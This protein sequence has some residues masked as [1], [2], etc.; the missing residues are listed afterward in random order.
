MNYIW[1]CKGNYIVNVDELIVAIV[2]DICDNEIE[3]KVKF[4]GDE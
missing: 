4:R 1:F 3:K 2:D